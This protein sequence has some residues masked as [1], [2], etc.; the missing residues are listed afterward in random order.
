MNG[1]SKFGPNGVRLVVDP[2][3][4]ATPAMVYLGN[5][6]ATYDCAMSEGMVEDNE[7]SQ[8]Q[9]DWLDAFQDQVAEAFNEA[10]KDMPEYS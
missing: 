9:Y 8:K 4:D 3:D 5:G 2:Q 6:S 1:F 7:L 10:R